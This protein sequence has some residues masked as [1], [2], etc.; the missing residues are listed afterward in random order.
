MTLTLIRLD[1]ADSNC[2]FFREEGR[3][4][5]RKYLDLCGLAGQE[6]SIHIK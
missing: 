6:W 3:K 1:D 4:A 2:C 5:I